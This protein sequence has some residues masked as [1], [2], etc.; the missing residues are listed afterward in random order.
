MKKINKVFLIIAGICGLLGAALVL[1]GVLMGA[2][3]G[4]GINTRGQL[5]NYADAKH[6]NLQKTKLEE[7][8][9]DIDANITYGNVYIETADDYYI[10]YNC[11]GNEIV[12]GPTY[13]VVDGK[14]TFNEP[15]YDVNDDKVFLNFNFDLFNNSDIE[16][17]YVKIYVPAQTVI[18]GIT[19][20]DNCGDIFFDGLQC[21]SV[22]ITNDYGDIELNNMNA[23]NL[24]LKSSCGNVDIANSQFGNGNIE[25]EYGTVSIEYSTIDVVN[26]DN[27]CGDIETE[28][29]EVTDLNASDDYGDMNLNLIGDMSL[30]DYEV[31]TDLGDVTFNG[32]SIGKSNIKSEGAEHKLIIKNDCGDISISFE[33]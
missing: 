13:E 7:N 32:K 14:L 8:I 10:E 33:E 15:Q 6:Y 5:V 26:I 22:D 30:Y 4:F 20:K 1:I 19:I 11:V 29:F 28:E 9:T 23:T 24:N 17:N 31:K 3:D 16:N 18:N 21:E 2:K 12:N 25:L 27:A